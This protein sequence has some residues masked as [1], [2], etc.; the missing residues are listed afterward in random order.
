MTN[1]TARARLSSPN[2]ILTRDN[3]EL[4][5]RDWMPAASHGPAAQ[6][7]VFVAG[8]SM[9]S[10][11][12][13]YQMMALCRQG[14]RCIAFD[15][16]GHGRSSDPGKN[17]DLDTLAQDL[18]AVLEALDLHGVA[19]VGHSMGCN[20]IVRYLGKHGR[21]RVRK[22]ALLGT[23]T[24]GVARN[25]SNPDGIDPAF[26]EQFRT[27]QL[28]V[29]FPLWIA[30]NIEPFAPGA[31]AGMQQWLTTMSLN[32]SL[33]ALHDCHVTVQQSDMAEELRQLDMA[34]LLI[35]GTCDASAPFAL[36]ARRS[37]DL[38]PGARLKVYEDAAHAMFLTHAGQVNRD[39][40]AFIAGEAAS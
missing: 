16:R 18:A 35:A 23:M 6:T 40:F 26:L 28:L 38:I 10:D 17:F 5:Y 30:E 34:T 37:A 14:M 20:E 25:A 21:A 29:D 1:P 11:A 4:F 7:V 9:P 32:S 33:Q 12:W 24:P 22:I 3:V 8:W 36:T 13:C 39:L 27:Q 19:L 2:R 31:S 15:R